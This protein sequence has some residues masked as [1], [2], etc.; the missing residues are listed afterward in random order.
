MCYD[1][2]NHYMIIKL[3]QTYYHYCE[4]DVATVNSFKGA[5]SMGRYYNANIRSKP[6]G[7]H[8]PFDC[9]DHPIPKY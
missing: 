6:D 2:A 3:K 4:I 8:G 1:T 9:R 7:T 5:A